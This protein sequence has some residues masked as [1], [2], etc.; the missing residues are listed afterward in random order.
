MNIEK[1]VT[2]VLS[3]YG[4]AGIVI[5]ALGSF[6]F[7]TVKRLI[8]AKSAHLSDIKEIPK[9]LEARRETEGKIAEGMTRIADSQSRIEGDVRSLLLRF[10]GDK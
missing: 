6:C 1:I 3:E 4:L 10:G 9:M 7:F 5:L 8:E 2:T